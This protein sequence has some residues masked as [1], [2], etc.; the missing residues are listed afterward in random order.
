MYDLYRGVDIVSI[1][2]MI[3]LMLAAQEEI[4]RKKSQPI[5]LRRGKHLLEHFHYIFI[6]KLSENAWGPRTTVIAMR[7]QQQLSNNS[8]YILYTLSSVLIARQASYFMQ[9][10]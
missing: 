9:K 4:F 8:I 6:R 10:L 2:H 7:E 3:T 5:Q 1:A